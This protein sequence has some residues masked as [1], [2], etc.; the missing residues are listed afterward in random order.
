MLIQTGSSESASFGGKDEGEKTDA[1]LEKL[2]NLFDVA[3]DCIIDGVVAQSKEQSKQLWYL[4]EAVAPAG[5]KHGFCLKY[6]VSLRPQDYYRCV[7]VA[8]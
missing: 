1:D 4:R 7:E 8:R 6:D 3:D 5:V 2:F